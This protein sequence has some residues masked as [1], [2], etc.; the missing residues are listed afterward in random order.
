VG[1]FMYIEAR[2]MT[3]EIAFRK[4]VAWLRGPE[5]PA[6]ASISDHPFG[7]VPD[8]RLP[9]GFSG[10]VRQPVGTPPNSYGG[11]RAA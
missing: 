3:P 4:F 1:F 10:P 5:T 9:R 8:P 7:F 2:D 11:R 6:I